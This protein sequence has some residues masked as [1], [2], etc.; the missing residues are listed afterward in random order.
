MDTTRT[1]K[2]GTSFYL[3]QDLAKDL[4]K[5]CYDVRISMSE[6]ATNSLKESLK[7]ARIAM[8]F[9]MRRKLAKAAR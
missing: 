4:R 2:E 3:P 6:F 9:A 1:P 7:K 5:Y 8:P